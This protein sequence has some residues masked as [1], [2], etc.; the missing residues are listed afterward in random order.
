VEEQVERLYDRTVPLPSGGSI[1]IDQTEALVAIDVN[2]GKFKDNDNLEETALQTNLEAAEVACR[3]LKLRDMGGVICIDFIDL[4]SEQQ[5]Q[6]IENLVR[7]R[8]ANDRARTRVAR[9]SRFCILELTRQR[10][11]MSIR[12]THYQS[13]SM[14]KGAGSVKTVQSM[15]LWAIRHL[16][17][18]VSKKAPQKGLEVTLHPDVLQYLTSKKRSELEEIELL[19]GQ[20]LRMKGDKGFTV[21]GFKVR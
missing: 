17:A 15:A 9:M 19:A 16:R 11:R 13:C 14:C 10:V 18:K 3:Q 1:V 7:D 21:E 4:R 2:S 12:K 20:Q 8:L 6:R 5:R